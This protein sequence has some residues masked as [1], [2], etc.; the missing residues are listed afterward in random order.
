MMDTALIWFG[1]IGLGVLIYV[2]LDGFD[3]GIGILFPL[4]KDKV[5]RDAMMNTVAP[6]WDGN[7]TWMVLGGAGLFGAFPLVYSTVLS[8][9]Y[10]PITLMALALIFRG[11][12]FEFRF[13]ATKGQQ[14]WDYAFIWGSILS[15][16]LQGVI[17]GAVIQGIKTENGIYAGGTFDWLTPFSLFVGF[18]VVVMYAALG[19]A[20]LIYKTAD[21][22]QQKMYRLKF[23]LTALLFVVFVAVLVISPM[24][25][26]S[27]A[28][29][30]FDGAHLVV[31][32][33]MS[34]LA[35]LFFYFIFRANQQQNEIK[36]FVYT[37]CLM[38]LAF[39]GLVFSL[40]PYII[41]PTIDIWQASAPRSS[42]LF[43][44]VG[45]AI[46]IPIIIAYTLLS[47]WVFRD[48]VRVGDEGYH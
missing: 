20:W 42:Q 46:F 24:I 19:C 41:P 39:V 43:A 40:F 44:L 2:V 14:F 47:Y 38:L 48:K 35:L 28:Q 34:A 45:A 36:P 3:L 31:F 10:L 23:P 13:K 17:L 27:I 15:S 4:V 1:I 22:L 8:A 26:P 32:V 6:V 5:E 29:R 37:I 9:L 12:S 11:V 33:V 16:F 21:E 18:G 25:A 30:W 7:E